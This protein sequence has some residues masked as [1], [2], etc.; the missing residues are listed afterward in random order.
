M[1]SVK[2]LGHIVLEKGV[3]T[4]P[5]KISALTTWPKPTNISELKS[6]LGFTGYYWRFVR[7]YS[8]IAKQLNSLTVGYCPPRRNAK[9]FKP[10]SNSDFKKPFGG[11]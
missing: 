5:E 4:D 11:R 10:A 3:E 2:Y 1:K 7:D 8:K 6:F 9:G